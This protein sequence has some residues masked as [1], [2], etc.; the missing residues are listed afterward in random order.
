VETKLPAHVLED[1]FY[2]AGKRF[3]HFFV[4]ESCG[5]S[6]MFSF[7]LGFLNMLEKSGPSKTNS[8]VQNINCCAMFGPIKNY[9]EML[10]HIVTTMNRHVDRI[11]KACL[12]SVRILLSSNPE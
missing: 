1:F 5:S 8:V 11:F 12:D 10:L 9:P 2:M 3:L 4:G 7:L 6:M